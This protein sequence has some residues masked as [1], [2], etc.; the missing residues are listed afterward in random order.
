MKSP[1]PPMRRKYVSKARPIC[2]CGSP[3]VNG[4]KCRNCAIFA[5]RGIDQAK[6]TI[7]RAAAAAANAPH[8]VAVVIAPP[9]SPAGNFDAEH[10]ARVLPEAAEKHEELRTQPV[11]V[12]EDLGD[13]TTLPLVEGAPRRVTSPFGSNDR[14]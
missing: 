1:R 3:A 10:R 8:A 13:R 2:L 12:V 11:A 14:R 7:A 6:E 4:A 9:V 5:A